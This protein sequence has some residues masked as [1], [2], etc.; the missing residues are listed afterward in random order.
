MGASPFVIELPSK[1]GGN[2]DFG[3]PCAQN[4]P[5]E[6]FAIG[7]AIGIRSIEEIDAGIESGRDHL[8][9]AGLIESASEIVAA[10]T[11]GRNVERTD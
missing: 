9:G 11:D 2:D 8:S 3:T 10:E 6:D 7:P 1:F 5:E 4:A